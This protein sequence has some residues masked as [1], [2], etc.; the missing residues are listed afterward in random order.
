MR[1]GVAYEVDLDQMVT[2][3]RL[4]E[5]HRLRIEITNSNFPACER[6]LN[7]GGNNYDEARSVFARTSILHDAAHP[8]YLELPLVKQ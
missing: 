4:A 2:A 3:I 7:T 6:N 5:G 1:P 8:D